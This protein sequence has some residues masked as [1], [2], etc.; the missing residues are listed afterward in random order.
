MANAPL[1]GAIDPPVGGNGRAHHC[2][3]PSA[4]HHRPPSCHHRAT[5]AHACPASPL[6][7]RRTS[8]VAGLAARQRTGGDRGNSGGVHHGG[9]ARELL[10][11]QI[12]IFDRSPVP[13]GLRRRAIGTASARIPPH[14]RT[15]RRVDPCPP[16]GRF[17]APPSRGVFPVQQALWVGGGGLP[18]SFRRLPEFSGFSLRMQ[19]LFFTFN[20]SNVVCARSASGGNPHVESPPRWPRIFTMR[21]GC[22]GAPWRPI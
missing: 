6:P 10:N 18:R 13:P 5:I 21:C 16:A 9:P 3:T 17:T 2:P 22:C 20:P 15:R 7:R 1:Q 11:I 14:L 19:T 4:G 8:P 12:Q